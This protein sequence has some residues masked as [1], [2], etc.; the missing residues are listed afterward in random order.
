MLRQWTEL[1]HVSREW[2]MIFM[3]EATKVF[4]RTQAGVEIVVG[5]R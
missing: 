4:G 1:S 5:L 2:F 3:L